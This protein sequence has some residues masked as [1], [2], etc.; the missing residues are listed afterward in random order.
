MNNPAG[1]VQPHYNNSDKA[2]QI[3]N[4]PET[5]RICWWCLELGAGNQVNVFGTLVLD[6]HPKCRE[7]AEQA[8][9]EGQPC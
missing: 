8:D 6:S 2:S 5:L 1:I 7:Q 3:K 9:A 4:E